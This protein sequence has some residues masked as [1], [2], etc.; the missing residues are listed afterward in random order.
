M[1]AVFA[2]QKSSRTSE[3]RVSE[4]IKT[5]V[6]A[7]V[8]FR[9]EPERTSGDE[10]QFL[11]S[12]PNEVLGSIRLLIGDGHWHVGV[13]IGPVE[14]PLPRD[15]RQS[16]GPAL[17]AAR[18]AVEDAKLLR[19]SIAVRGP[20]E[21]TGEAE[22]LVQLLAHLWEERSRPGWQAV[23]AVEAAGSGATL[24]EVARSLSISKQALS[25]RL[26]AANWHLERR[27]APAVAAALGR[28]DRR[29]E[30]S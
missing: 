5:L 30:G 28:A 6:A 18:E 11:V 23:S 14:S 3:D 25:Q 4:M 10:F 21:S 1:F 9:L 2:D 12:K 20:E 16:R 17:I 8:E 22:A 13:G 24:S 26:Q 27:S 29:Q 19:P 15:V 7:N